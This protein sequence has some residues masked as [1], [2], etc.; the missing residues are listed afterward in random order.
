[1]ENK[2]YYHGRRTSKSNFYGN[3]IYITDNKEYAKLYSDGSNIYCFKIPNDTYSKIFSLPDDYEKIK[4]TIHPYNIDTIENLSKTNREL[5]YATVDYIGSNMESDDTFDIILTSLGYT[6]IKL[7]ERDGIESIMIFEQNNLEFIGM[8]TFEGK[9]EPINELQSTAYGMYTSDYSGIMAND[10]GISFE[11]F[12][13]HQ[14]TVNR[15]IQQLN[16]ISSELTNTSLFQR[17]KNELIL[18]DQRIEELRVL[19]II[20]N[21][22]NIYNAYLQF[23]ID[24]VEYDGV[25]YDVIGPNPIFKSNVFKSNAVVLTKEWIVRIS[26]YLINTV[27]EWITPE[28]GK[29]KLLKDYVMATDKLTGEYFKIDKDS[30]IEV[31][32]T[33]DDDNV[34][35]IKYSE[36][37]LSLHNKNF[38]YFNYYFEEV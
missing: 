15:S 9:I 35:Y 26:G 23:I 29:Y 1:M 38:V 3:S 8:L 21:T 32:D 2:I 16:D 5:D 7:N 24:E 4:D 27:V 20:P 31:T 14:Q 30:I 22:A 18:D 37:K 19:R 33:D 17:L 6:G 34:V 12:Y 28:P 36:R 10:P 11:P 13:R 25:I